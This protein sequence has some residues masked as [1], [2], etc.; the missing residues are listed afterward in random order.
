MLTH[1]RIKNIAVIEDAEIE[2]GEGLNILSGETGAGKSII[3]D[4]VNLVLGERADRDMIRSGQDKAFVEAFFDVSDS[5][6]V[7]RALEDLFEAEYDELVIS[8]EM[9]NKGRNICR[10]NGRMATL[11]QLREITS[12]LLDIHGQHQHQ[13]L[14]NPENHLHILDGFCKD[15]IKSHLDHYKLHLKKYHEVCHRLES[16]QMDE[17]DRQRQLEMLQYQLKEIKEVSPVVGEE[18]ELKQTRDKLQNAEEIKASLDR[19]YSAMF[20]DGN[21]DGAVSSLYQANEGY[22]KIANIDDA[23]Q[24]IY[25]RLEQIIVECD[26]IAEEIREQHHAFEFDMGDMDSIETRLSQLN[27]L[28]RKYGPSIEDVITYQ[29]RIELQISDLDENEILLDELNRKKTQLEKELMS[30]GTA[31]SSIRTQYGEKLRELI[32]R[33][34]T[35]LGMKNARFLVKIEMEQDAQG[36]VR[37]LP[38]GLD[39]VE[40]MITTNVGESLKPLHKIVSGGELSRIMLALK[41]ISANIDAI[42]TLIFDE[43][44]TGISGE[45]TRVVGEKLASI[46]L[47]KQVICVTHAAQ[48]AAMADRHLFIHKEDDTNRTRTKITH[49][50]DDERYK[51]ISRLVGGSKVS[52]LS[53]EHAKNIINWSKIY[54]DALKKERI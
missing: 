29:A 12:N 24:A 18:E 25:E 42:Q 41:N 32:I 31:I 39:R 27:Q 46:A 9:S 35:D 2:L 8:R 1:L 28:R 5:P 16:L 3:I 43:I 54:K 33:Q 45:M 6:L 17:R 10:I 34:L 36:K 47:G 52:A 7:Q 21:T 20:G 49:L 11:V 15:E 51:E 26:D 50:E 44:D 38:D 22:S 13:S 53:D 23:Y 14:L 37:Y 40:F 4:S 30:S 19:A 48:I